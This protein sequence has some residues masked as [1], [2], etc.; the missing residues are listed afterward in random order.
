MLEIQQRL[1]QSLLECCRQLLHDIDWESIIGD[2]AVP[3]EPAIK[4]EGDWDSLAGIA[5]DAPCR[6][7]GKLDLASIEEILDAKRSAIEDHILALREDLGYAAEVANDYKEHRSELI[8][9][10]Q[11]PSTPISDFT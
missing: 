9:R 7:P 8:H 5:V 6:L 10:Y 2:Y 4:D 11:W 3:P 1:Y